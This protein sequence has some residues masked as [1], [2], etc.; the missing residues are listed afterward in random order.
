MIAGATPEL[1]AWYGDYAAHD[2][3]ARA[4]VKA[5]ARGPIWIE[6]KF[7]CRQCQT[8]LAG[9]YAAVGTI[10]IQI[11][12]EIEID[13]KRVQVRCTHCGRLNSCYAPDR[14]P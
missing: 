11:G 10:A 8:R 6:D 12:K 2:A 9:V 7:R 1:V 3:A 5:G 13:R 4:M 14:R